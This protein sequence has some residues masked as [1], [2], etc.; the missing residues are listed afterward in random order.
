MRNWFSFWREHRLSLLT[1][2]GFFLLGAIFGAIYWKELGEL[3]KEVI[4]Q[5]VDK[6][7][8]SPGGETKPFQLFWGLLLNNSL[9]SL[10]LIISGLLFGI[11]PAWGMLLNGLIIGYMLAAV[12]YGGINPFSMFFFG[13][14]P[15]GIFEI[16]AL[17]LAA[18]YGFIL[19]A[20]VFQTIIRLFRPKLREER[21]VKWGRIWR[22]FLPTVIVVLLLL[23]VAAAIESSLTLYLVQT[24][25]RGA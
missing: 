2:I 17:V 23:V 9:A 11:M 6:I 5:L 7:G 20:A 15:H 19:G 1:A 13:I 25:V 3:M 16:P 24:F 4:T 14:L 10:V 18:S 8:I 22:F 12:G 21:P